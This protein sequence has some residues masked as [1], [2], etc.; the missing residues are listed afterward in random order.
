MFG[1]IAIAVVYSCG[2]VLFSGCQEGFTYYNQLCGGPCFQLD[3]ILGYFD[4]AFTVFLPLFT[5]LVFNTSLILRVIYQ[6]RRMLQRNIWRKNIRMLGQLLTVSL[7]HVTV[8]IP[9]VTVILI[10]LTSSPPPA[11]IL[12]LQA[13]WVLINLMYLAVL[14]NPIVSIIAIP[15][16][17]AKADAWIRRLKYKICGGRIEPVITVASRTANT[18][19]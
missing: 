1:V 7:L 2:T 19:S 6:K 12:D 14:G 18:Q 9:V 4:L 15:E 8:W 11:I 17:N 5:I 13:S 3:P 10:A 16:I